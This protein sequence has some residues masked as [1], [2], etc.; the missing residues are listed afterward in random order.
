MECP[1]SCHRS[2]HPGQLWPG[3][4]FLGFGVLTDDAENFCF[5]PGVGVGDGSVWPV[6]LDELGTD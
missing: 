3:E 2:H 5:Q 6:T 4:G 1:E